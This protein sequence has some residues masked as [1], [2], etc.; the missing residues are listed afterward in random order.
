MLNVCSFCC[1]RHSNILKYVSNRHIDSLTKYAVG[2]KTLQGHELR[3][4]LPKSK[5]PKSVKKAP[6]DL[7]SL[8]KPLPYS[9]SLNNSN[10]I[11]AELG[12]SLDRGERQFTVFSNSHV[13][14]TFAKNNIFTLLFILTFN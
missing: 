4:R 10:G 13:H 12:G 14:M 11:G 3:S 6:N 7:E 8:V 2:F 9:A 5:K 1:R